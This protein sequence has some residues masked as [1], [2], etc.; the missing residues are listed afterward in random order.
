MNDMTDSE[1]VARKRRLRLAPEARVPLIL[2]AAL[3]EFS[4]RGFT[5]ARMDDIAQR[6][7]LSKGGLYAHFDSKDE[8]FKALLDRT[9]HRTN[10]AEMPQLA[11]GADTHA[12]AEWI[13]ERL[14]SALLAPDV[15]TLLRLLIPERDRV[16]LRVAEWKNLIQLHT[17]QET[18]VISDNLTAGGRQGCVLA[19][20]P[21]LALSPM[22][23]VL[24]WRAVL[25]E[26]SA[27][28]AHYR[29]AHVDLLCE[30]LA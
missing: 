11:T 1:T 26:E 7:G 29:Q 25:G 14:Q 8:I 27:P 24:L 22:V 6:C 2:D 18:A 15:I 20:H 23:H 28:D 13:V 16:P 9:L 3:E 12:V 5:A 10:W 19:R 30:L 21:W 17:Q 4:R